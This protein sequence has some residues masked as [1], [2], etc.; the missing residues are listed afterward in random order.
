VSATLNVLGVIASVS[1]ALIGIAGSLM[2][3]N[4]YHPFSFFGFLRTLP[5]VAWRFVIG[6]SSRAKEYLS[7]TQRL[8]QVNA[9][10]RTLS[11][12]GLCL[13]FGGFVLQLVGTILSYVGSIASG[14]P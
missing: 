8:A 10:D 7:R 2:M 3:A 14:T 11:L 5:D 12:A 1:G 9:E 4:A 6:G 13:I